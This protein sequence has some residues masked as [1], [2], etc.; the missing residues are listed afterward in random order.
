MFDCFMVVS[1][2]NNVININK[3]NGDFI[4]NVFFE[5][6]MINRGLIKTL[7]KKKIG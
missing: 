1:S 6:R 5:Q 2:D 7:A 3:D 4:L